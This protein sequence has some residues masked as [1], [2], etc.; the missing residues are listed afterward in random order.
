MI[1]NKMAALWAQSPTPTKKSFSKGYGVD[2]THAKGICKLGVRG[3]SYGWIPTGEPYMT[4]F[5]G[6]PTEDGRY[7]IPLHCHGTNMISG[8]TFAAAV[9]AAAE[10]SNLVTAS[11]EGNILTFSATGTVPLFPTGFL[12]GAHAEVFTIMF[13]LCAPENTGSTLNSGI[14]LTYSYGSQSV[15]YSGSYAGETVQILTS[16]NAS[17]QLTGLS[18]SSTGGRPRRI[19]I[20]T[21]GIFR[22]T[23]SQ[24]AFQPYWGETVP[25]YLSEPLRTYLTTKDIAY[26]LQGYAERMVKATPFK[27]DTAIPADI[28]NAYPI[29]RLPMP[30]A[31]HGQSVLMDRFSHTTK[32]STLIA[33]ELRY[34]Q[35]AEKDAILVCVP[36]AYKTAEKFLNFFHATNANIISERDEPLIERFSPIVLP[37]RRGR[38][39]IDIQTFVA[40][41]TIDFTYL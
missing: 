19:D 28:S 27:P 29:Y 17:R 41:S 5:F 11:L 4:T 40:P 3:T 7:V 39:H 37:T 34:M 18:V 33:E 16:S 2:L 6:D 22:G 32:E 13:T 24:E 15:S 31:L 23:V 8:E 20:S 12:R 38:N 36:S 35:S 14:T 26:P 10:S 25:F 30:E 21:F 1:L 9:L